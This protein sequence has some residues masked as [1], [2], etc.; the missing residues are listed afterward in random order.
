M[1]EG[2]IYRGWENNGTSSARQCIFFDSTSHKYRLVQAA[3]SPSEDRRRGCYFVLPM[4]IPIPSVRTLPFPRFHRIR[5]GQYLS[6]TI[7]RYLILIQN[8]AWSRFTRHENTTIQENALFS[9]VRLRSPPRRSR[10][11]SSNDEG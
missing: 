11:D 5:Y 10:L 6:R 1:I 9:T 7:H 4:C 8:S 2:R 3:T